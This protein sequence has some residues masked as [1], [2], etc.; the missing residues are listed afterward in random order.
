MFTSRKQRPD[1]EPEPEELMEVASR[2]RATEIRGSVWF[3]WGIRLGIV[4]VFLGIVFGM[5]YVFLP[6]ATVSIVLTQERIESGDILIIADPSLDD[7]EVDVENGVI[8]TLN[9][10]VTV[11]N[12]TQQYNTTGSQESDNVR[13]TGVV[14]FINRTNNEVSI[15]IGTQVST[16]TGSPVQFRTLEPV[17]LAASVDDEVDVAVEAMPAFSGEIGNVPTSFINTVVGP[18]SDEVDV[19]NRIPTTGG[20]NLS[21]NIV[22]QADRDTFATTNTPDNTDSRFT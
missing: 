7:F 5:I 18:L 4:A 10:D 16:G 19:I 9:I 15:P 12:E 6:T 8:P 17:T 14:T 22:T 1:S 11:E 2:V 3:R 21:V 13:A 20:E